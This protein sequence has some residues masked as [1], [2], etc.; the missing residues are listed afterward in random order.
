MGLCTADCTKSNPARW[1]FTI[2]LRLVNWFRKQY[3]SSLPTVEQEQTKLT[4]SKCY[5]N[6]DIRHGYRQLPVQHE[7]RESQS[8]IIPDNVYKPTTVFHG[9]TYAFLHFQAFL[10]MSLPPDLKGH[11]IF[12]VDDCLF[13]GRTME[14][15]LKHISLLLTFRANPYCKPLPAK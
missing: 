5:A 7:S 8:F 11:T 15:L 9:T 12:W 2:D 10:T 1:R 14:R 4:A 3:Q 6:L 13:H